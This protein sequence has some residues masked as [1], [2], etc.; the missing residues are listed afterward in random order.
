MH[1][2]SVVVCAAGAVGASGKVVVGLVVEG[3]G[4]SKVDANNSSSGLRGGMGSCRHMAV[5]R[6]GS[7]RSRT[8]NGLE[9]V[10]DDFKD[11]LTEMN[12]KRELT[13]VDD[14][15]RNGRVERKLALITEG[16]RAAWLEFPRH[17]PDLQFPR[18]ALIWDKIWPEA[19]SWMNDGINISARV[20]DNP[21]MLC[22]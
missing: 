19:F 1:S 20:D 7:N 11:M 10:N 2:P 17:F 16:A 21:D 9:F 6:C 5:G 15:K 22:P 4:N 13:P 18:T 14:A 8:D 12:I 3:V